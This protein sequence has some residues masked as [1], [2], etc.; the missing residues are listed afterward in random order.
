LS[1]V[2][3]Y[4]IEN[5]VTETHLGTHEATSPDEALDVLGV[6]AG[7]HDFRAFERDNCE[8]ADEWRIYLMH[9]GTKRLRARLIHGVLFDA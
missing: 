9:D 8:E 2:S 7:Y 3:T 4:R 1:I 6:A 5:H